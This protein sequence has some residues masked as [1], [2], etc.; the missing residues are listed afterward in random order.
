MYIYIYTQSHA[1]SYHRHA[2]IV[3]HEESM[4]S[5]KL[6]PGR[7]LCARHGLPF[8]ALV[9]IVPE[10]KKIRRYRACVARALLD[11]GRNILGVTSP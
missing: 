3:F 1:E 5:A 9:Y 6:R 10:T 4:R 8:F 7:W 2:V 11:I